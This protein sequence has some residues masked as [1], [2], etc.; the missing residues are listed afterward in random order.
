MHRPRDLL[1]SGISLGLRAQPDGVMT[2]SLTVSAECP[3]ST[4]VDAVRPRFF[5]NDLRGENGWRSIRV[6]T[7]KLPLLAWQ[8]CDSAGESRAWNGVG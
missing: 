8:L 1:Q 3:T 6:R 7:T 5:L 4:A 2:A